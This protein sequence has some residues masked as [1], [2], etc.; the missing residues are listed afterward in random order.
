MG[1]ILLV[2]HAQASFG[3]DD[4]DRLSEL[5]FTQASLLGR[6]F[7]SCD[8]PIDRAM[9]G[10]MRRHH[11]TAR[12]CLEQ[13]GASGAPELNTDPRLNEFDHVEVFD[14]YRQSLL[15]APAGNPH[16]QH[17]EQD[18]QAAP[19][20]AVQ[21][22]RMFAAA[23][24]RWMSSRH[25]GDYR[26]SWQA[27][28]ARCLD[29]FEEMASGTPRAKAIVVFTSG[30][31]IAAICQRLLDLTDKATR[32]LNWSLANTG[33]TRVL[34]S[35]GRRGLGYLNST[36]HFDAARVPHLLTYR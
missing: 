8:T 34:F 26:D 4:Y 27:F 15:D 11:E 36:A 23:M 22:Q 18:G 13:R 9:A 33:V 6:W 2:R 19:L 25:D 29:A 30:G 7:E 10:A 17:S 20:S 32:E 31:V 35:E 28:R 16:E 5:G 3:S 12:Q 1:Q 21:L 14:V 24:E